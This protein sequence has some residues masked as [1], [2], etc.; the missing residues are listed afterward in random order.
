MTQEIPEAEVVGTIQEGLNKIRAALNTYDGLTPEQ[1]K[2]IRHLIYQ[3]MGG[4]GKL[5]TPLFPQFIELNKEF[6]ETKPN[7]PIEA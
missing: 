5:L 2:E 4:Y 1:Q 3:K 6:K 7:V